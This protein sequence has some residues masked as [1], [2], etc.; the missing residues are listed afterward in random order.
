MIELTQFLGVAGA[1]V[2]VALV[3]V[4]RMVFPDWPDRVAP[5]MAFGW[6]AVIN[7]VVAYSLP[8]AWPVA[9]L[10]WILCALVASGVYSQGKAASGN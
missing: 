3:A 1:P 7:A 9:I 4:T 8:V 5:L 2:V 6:A 10:A